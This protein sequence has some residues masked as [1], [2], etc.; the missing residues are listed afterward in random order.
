VLAVP[1]SAVVEINTRPFVFV[2][3]EGESF[4]KR[5]VQLGGASGDLIE[6]EQ[7]VTENERIVTRGGF[8]I[9][10]ASLMGSVESHRH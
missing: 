8:D 9:H 7:G 1:R 10:L 6:I 2:Q 5:A 3:T 4:E